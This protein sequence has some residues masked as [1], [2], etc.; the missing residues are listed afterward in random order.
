[1]EFTEA[2]IE[3]VKDEIRYTFKN[4]EIDYDSLPIGGTRGDADEL[5]QYISKIVYFEIGRVLENT[6]QNIEDERERL[7]NEG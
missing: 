6:Y 7:K 1:M 5:A 4:L 3:M 2:E